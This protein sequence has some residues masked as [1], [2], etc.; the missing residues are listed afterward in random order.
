[1]VLGLGNP[2]LSDDAVGLKVVERFRELLA[3]R[4][5][6]EVDV[7][8]SMRGGLDL[9]DLLGGYARAVI[10]DALTLPE[11]SPGRVHELDLSSVAGMVRLVGS[12]EISVSQAF[13]L[14][15]RFDIPMPGEVV[16][17]GIEAGEVLEFSEELTP[18][19]ARAVEPLARRIHSLL[20]GLQGSVEGDDRH[21]DLAQHSAS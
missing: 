2:V 18:P 10:V 20:S 7:S 1:M 6:Q 21:E 13:Q 16:I 4:P 14:A 11:P 15:A 8:C 19:V 17:F 5:L 12:H 9:L 3:E